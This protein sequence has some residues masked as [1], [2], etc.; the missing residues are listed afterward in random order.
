MIS[1]CVS[2]FYSINL[3]VRMHDIHNFVTII[4]KTT[5][6]VNIDDNKLY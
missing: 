6:K 1:A 4:T 3:N 2:I 5:A